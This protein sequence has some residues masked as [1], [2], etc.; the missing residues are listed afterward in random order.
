MLWY[1]SFFCEWFGRLGGLGFWLFVCDRCVVCE[2]YDEYCLVINKLV[3]FIDGVLIKL[4]FVFSW[5]LNN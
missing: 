3:V 2:I 4:L 1:V 5:L